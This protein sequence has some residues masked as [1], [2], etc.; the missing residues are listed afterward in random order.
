MEL[1]GLPEFPGKFPEN[2]RRHP[3]NIP[4]PSRIP[5]VAQEPPRER[6]GSR[7]GLEMVRKWD[8]RESKRVQKQY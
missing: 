3:R 7:N 2:P 1:G 8:P 5:R 4:E 6:P